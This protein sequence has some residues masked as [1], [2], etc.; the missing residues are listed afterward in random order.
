MEHNTDIEKPCS[1]KDLIISNDNMLKCCNCGA[2]EEVQLD[3]ELLEEYLKHFDYVYMMSDA[4]NIWSAGIKQEE[5]IQEMIVLASN[6]DAERTLKLIE[7][8]KQEYG[9]QFQVK[10]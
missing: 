1:V 3:W 7:K 10:L 6:I 8:Y 5:V 4:H 2:I 9:T